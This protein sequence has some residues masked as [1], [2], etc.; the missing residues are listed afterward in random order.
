ME[1]GKSIMA[2]DPGKINEIE[3][4]TCGPVSAAIRPPSSK[5]ITNRALICAALAQGKTDLV[6]PLESDD[7]HV[8]ID[9]LKR[10]GIQVE[11]ADDV[12]T[13]HGCG[14][15]IPATEAELFIGNSGTSVRFLTA[16]LC[17]GNGNF[18]IDGVPRMRE[19]PIGDLLNALRQIGAEVES[20]TDC[21][22]VNVAAKGLNGGE[23]TIRGDI[24]SQYLSGLLMS[25]PYARESV[26]VRVDGELVSRPYVDMTTAIMQAF[27]ISVESDSDSY[28]VPA[29]G[30]QGQRFLVEPDASAA[31]YFWA[32]A[33]I[34]GGTATV[35]ELGRDSLQ[36][37]VGFCDLLV[38]MGC[39]L[40][41]SEEGITISRSGPLKGI[42]CDMSNVSDTAQT[43]SAVALFA[44]GPTT[45]RGIAHNRHKETDRIGNLA[46]ELRKFGAVVDEFDDGFRVVP[47]DELIPAEVDTYDDHRMAMSL[48]L[49]GLIV[50]GTIIRDPGCTAK[51]YPHFF[52]DL[53]TFIGGAQ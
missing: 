13:V 19:R 48:A 2:T 30:Y 22:P 3:V 14:G 32:A 33:A 18:T 10:L 43:L 12:V 36:G 39:S 21:P 52:E 11:K 45:I 38:E 24:S 15:N 7:T 9:S 49:P 16:L 8:M 20:E 53:K 6:Q 27:G 47:P 29:A 17:L 44:A 31:S 4:P 23:V 35:R 34:T 37:D 28:R 5:S 25:A 40:K 51:T 41:E 50:P 46:I 42:D 1:S 26:T